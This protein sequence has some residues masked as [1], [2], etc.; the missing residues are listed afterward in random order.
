[1]PVEIKEIKQFGE[2]LF[3]IKIKDKNTILKNIVLSQSE[4][5]EISEKINELKQ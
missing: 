5:E 1:M 2:P 4:I 3:D